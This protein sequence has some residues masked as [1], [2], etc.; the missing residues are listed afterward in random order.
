QRGP[1]AALVPGVHPVVPRETDS[2]RPAAETREAEPPA[3]VRAVE[4]PRGPLEP[5]ELAPDEALVDRTPVARR[6]IRAVRPGGDDRIRREDAV[7]EGV[8]DA[9]THEGI[10]SDRIPYE[11]RISRRD[12]TAVHV[13]ANGERLPA[14]RPRADVVEHPRQLA[15][16]LSARRGRERVRARV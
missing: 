12:G 5:P 6:R 2:L 13:R 10:A 8:R 9:F 16:H 14:G 11:E 4:V 15:L 3:R 1:S 7:L